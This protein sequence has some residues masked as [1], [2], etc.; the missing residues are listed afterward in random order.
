MTQLKTAKGENRLEKA[1]ATSPA[2]TSGQIRLQMREVLTL[3]KC[4]TA[5]GGIHLRV[6]GG[7][8]GFVPHP[9]T[10]T[11]LCKAQCQKEDISV[12]SLI[13]AGIPMDFRHIACMTATFWLDGGNKKMAAL[14]AFNHTLGQHVGEFPS[15]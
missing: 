8:M 5:D 4:K 11:A 14:R 2:Q 3:S 6:E 12:P 13:S 10:D 15:I 9:I 1:S 7:D